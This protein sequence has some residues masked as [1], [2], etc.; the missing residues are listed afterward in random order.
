MKQGF[1]TWVGWLATDH[2]HPDWN[3]WSKFVTDSMHAAFKLDS[4]RA[5]HPIEVPVKSA[6]DV[7]Q[8]FDAISY[9][10]GKGHH[11]IA[12]L[13]VLLDFSGPRRKS[14]D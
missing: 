3:Y 7:D 4:M 8:I 13:I 11:S 5:S 12:V 10:K 14:N 1:A 9:R 2:L 6:V